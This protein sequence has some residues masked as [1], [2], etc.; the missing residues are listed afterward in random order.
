MVFCNGLRRERAARP[1]FDA[2]NLEISSEDEVQ[3]GTMVSSYNKQSQNKLPNCL[4]AT[5]YYSCMSAQTPLN[6]DRYTAMISWAVSVFARLEY[7]SVRKPSLIVVRP[8]PTHVV[9]LMTVASRT[10]DYF[11]LRC[12]YMSASC[13]SSP[14]AK[15]CTV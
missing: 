4:P 15:H 9:G 12:I 8:K 6:Q 5:T 7:A 2:M 10:T 1:S 11:G 14:Y 3:N 13:T